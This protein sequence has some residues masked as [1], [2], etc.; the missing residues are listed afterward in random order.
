MSSKALRGV[1]LAAVVFFLP[2]AGAV[3]AQDIDQNMWG[4]NGRVI[5]IVREGGVVYIGGN[6]SS[7]YRVT[8]GGVQV[9][10]GSGALPAIFPKVN[11]TVR[12]V[13]SDG[14]G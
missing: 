14:V 10:A 4:T 9:D 2:A 7:V 11:G 5:A 3:Q 12:A 1:G 13:A 8:G 6:F